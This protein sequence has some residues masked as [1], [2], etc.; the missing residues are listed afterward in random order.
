MGG[1]SEARLP[2]IAITGTK[3]GFISNKLG[4]S[5]HWQESQLETYQVMCYHDVKPFE[6]P[7]SFR[8]IVSKCKDIMTVPV[9]HYFKMYEI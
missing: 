6:Q 9:R 1:R 3:Q 4:E 8:P 2:P 7:S 5:Q